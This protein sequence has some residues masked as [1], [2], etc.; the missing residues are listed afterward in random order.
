MTA[1]L[2]VMDDQM[3]RR[4]LH[5]TAIERATDAELAA[6]SDELSTELA[7][8]Q[9]DL[10]AQDYALF[11]DATLRSGIAYLEYQLADIVKQSERRLRARRFAHHPKVEPHEDFRSRFDAMRCADIVEAI[12]TLGTLLNKRGKE[13]WGL[14]S[15]HHERTPS[16]AVNLEK[17]FWRCHGCQRGGDLV[18]FVMQ[19]RHLN[20]IEALGFLEAIVSVPGVAA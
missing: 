18:S 10:A 1:S 5:R 6:M 11:D 15:F 4:L 13:W 17:G 7:L 2:P 8:L 14:C 3:S 20:A 16:F 12:Q 9:G 19:Q